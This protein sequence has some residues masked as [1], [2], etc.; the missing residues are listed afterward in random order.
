MYFECLW[1]HR[2]QIISKEI[3]EEEKEQ[4]G[5]GEPPLLKKISV[6]FPP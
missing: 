5:D 3:Y 2:I 4:D 6:T 1:Q